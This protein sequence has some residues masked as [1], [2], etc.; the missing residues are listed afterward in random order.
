MIILSTVKPEGPVVHEALHQL[1][2]T[3][4]AGR[5]Q[6]IAVAC[7]QG[8]GWTW[9]DEARGEAYSFSWWNSG[10]IFRK[11]IKMWIWLI[12]V[13]HHWLCEE[14]VHTL[15]HC[16]WLSMRTNFYGSVGPKVRLSHDCVSISGF[17][18]TIALGETPLNSNFVVFSRF[19]MF[20]GSPSS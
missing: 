17:L 18:A 20:N 19:A 5:G 6:W 3:L 9:N 12:M 7:E 15:N 4:I 1:W 14:I 8:P 10:V 16:T 13:A 11:S 2:R